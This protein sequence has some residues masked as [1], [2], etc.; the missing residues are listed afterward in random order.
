MRAGH[1]RN[2]GMIPWACRSLPGALNW[3]SINTQPMSYG[4]STAL[5]SGTNEKVNHK[6][7]HE[8]MLWDVDRVKRIGKLLAGEQGMQHVMQQL[9]YLPTVCVNTS[10]GKEGR[11]CPPHVQISNQ[12]GPSKTSHANKKCGV[13]IVDDDSR[14]G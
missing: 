2:P 7:H 9:R 8:E 10:N 1:Y 14:F 5:G 12:H 4:S 6:V 11:P 3:K 13:A